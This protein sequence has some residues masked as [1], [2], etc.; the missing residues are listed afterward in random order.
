MY[1][2]VN[3]ECQRE[4]TIGKQ[5]QPMILIQMSRTMISGETSQNT[6]LYK[7]HY[8]KPHV[9]LRVNPMVTKGSQ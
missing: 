5:E 7:Y 8:Q 3:N 4:V 6:P 9:S 2:V 1:L